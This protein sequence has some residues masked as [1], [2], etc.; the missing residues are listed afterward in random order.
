MILLRFLL[1]S[2][3]M[4]SK[5]L[6]GW[7]GDKF[8]IGKQERISEYIYMQRWPWALPAVRRLGWG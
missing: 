4:P 1:L 2:N 6:L 5:D 8:S 3:M 7:S